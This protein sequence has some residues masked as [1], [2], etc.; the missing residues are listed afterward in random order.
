M[1]ALNERLRE[2]LWLYSGV[3]GTCEICA[4]I[5]P[6]DL[7]QLNDGRRDAGGGGGGGGSGVAFIDRGT[8]TRVPYR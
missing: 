3:A 6:L 5:S 4:M 2:A 7:A 8:G 1:G